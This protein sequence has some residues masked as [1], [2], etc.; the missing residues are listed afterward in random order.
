MLCLHFPVDRTR[1]F[2]Q[3]LHAIFVAN[4]NLID[5]VFFIPPD[6]LL[7]NKIE[8]DSSEST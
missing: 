1:S 2:S 8:K 7:F 4:G 6:T 5:G 3:Y